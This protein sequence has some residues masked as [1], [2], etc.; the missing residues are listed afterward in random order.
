MKLPEAEIHTHTR[1]K[2]EKLTQKGLLLLEY[3]CDLKKMGGGISCTIFWTVARIDVR[4]KLQTLLPSEWRCDVRDSKGTGRFV[5]VVALQTVLHVKVWYLCKEV[6]KDVVGLKK[7][8]TQR[9]YR[10]R[11][12]RCQYQLSQSIH[13]IILQTHSL[14]RRNI[15]FHLVL[16]AVC[17]LLGNSPASDFFYAYVSEHPVPSS[18]AGSYLP[19]YEDGTD[20]LFRNV[21]I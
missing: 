14:E 12:N 19:A 1:R 20:T 4:F 6:Q 7:L 13:S 17:F 8:S 18:Y 11:D 2:W 3:F 15:S 9:A 21:G 5:F 10:T 16:N